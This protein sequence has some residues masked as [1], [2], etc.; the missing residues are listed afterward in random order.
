[1]PDWVLE[2]GSTAGEQQTEREG[3]WLQKAPDP[4]PGVEWS[5]SR[6]LAATTGAAVTRAI[7]WA[8][9]LTPSD[10]WKNQPYVR[11]VL[12]FVARNVAQVGVHMFERLSDT[13][14]RRVTD[15]PLAALLTL[16]PNN[17]TTAYE[18]WYGT[19]LDRMLYDR[20]YW[21]IGK[22]RSTGEDAIVRIPARRVV[23]VEGEDVTEEPTAY[24]VLNGRGERVKVQARQVLEFPGYDPVDVDGIPSSPLEA[25]KSVIAEQAAAFAFRQATWQNGAQVSGTITR[26]NDAPGWSPEAKDRFM[27]D[28]R[29]QFAGRGPQRGG[30]I[31]LEEGMTYDGQ[32]FNAR[33]AEWIDAAKLSLALVASMYH[34]NPTMVGLMDNA[35]YSNVKAFHEMLYQDTLGPTFAELEQRL[36]AFL[37]PRFADTERKY[38]EFNIAE[39]LEGSFTE[40]AQAYQTASGRPWLTTNEVRARQ[41]L[42]PIEGGDELV[43]PLNVLVGGQASPTDAGP[44]PDPTAPPELPASSRRE[45]EGKRGAKRHILQL[46]AD[47]PAAVVQRSVDVLTGFFRRQADVIRSRA[48]AGNTAYQ[49]E[50][51]HREL[52]AAILQVSVLASTTAGRAT[53]EGLGLE[54]DEWDE[55][56]T[57]GWL[58]AN[59][60]G[61]AD[62]VNLTV[63]ARVGE[64]LAEAA[65]LED[66]DADP[67]GDTLGVI[68]GSYAAMVATSQATAMTGWG[69]IEAVNQ[70]GREATKTWETGANPRSAHAALSGETVPVGDTFSNGARWPG[71]SSLSDDE[72][73][74]CNCGLTVNLEA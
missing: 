71:D 39:K 67:L 68:A 46:K 61:V 21:G 48:G 5:T 12:P 49:T 69:T 31:L 11:I 30:V 20:A 44:D 17:R 50:R 29:S 6:D 43:T 8:L 66:P 59:A 37:L 45:L 40:Q 38:F 15:H 62:G 28:V 24:W 22:S 54:P 10:V 47:P 56:R 16:K 23:E 63:K 73:A 2:R 52:K 18:L 36:N 27:A 7:R 60:D 57:I 34:V 72:R 13:N 70:T 19:Q 51:W 41:N 58:D 65:E 14:R 35:N 74:G 64:A 26:P 1:M 9:N 3:R 32:Q 53:L 33:E 25:L 4:G 55:D 42:Q